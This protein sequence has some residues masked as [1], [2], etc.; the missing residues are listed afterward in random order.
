MRKIEILRKICI[1][2]FCESKHEALN[3]ITQDDAIREITTKKTGE[4]FFHL[5]FP[6]DQ[7]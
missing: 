2:C 7:F 4:V 5:I 6:K 1:I 3:V